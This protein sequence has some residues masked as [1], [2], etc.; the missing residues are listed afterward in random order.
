MKLTK[1]SIENHQFTII[2][3]IILLIFGANSFLTMPRMEDEPATTPGALVIVV[4]PGA[5][6]IDL[7]Q[8]V[9]DPIE[10]A[11]NEL[12]DIKKIETIIRD[13]IVAVNVD[14]EYSGVD[15]DDKYNEVVQQINSI[16]IDLPEDI[17]DINIVKKTTTDTKILQ[18]A[19]VSEK[20]E[21]SILEKEAEKLKKEIEKI[22]GIKKVE[23]LAVPKREVRISMDVEKMAQMNITLDHVINAVNS[24][25]ANIPGGMIEL[26]KKHFNIKTSGSYNNL[27][28]IRNTV[29]YSYQGKLIYLKNIAR[30]DF[31]YEDNYYHA[32]FNKRHCIYITA[33]QKENVNI[34]DLTEETAKII[35]K[36]KQN[37]TGDMDLFYVFDQ[38]ISVENSINDFIN[39]LIQGIIL[40]GFL[41]LLAVGFKA[42]IVVII[43]IPMSILIGIGFVDMSGFGLQQISI[44]ALVIALGLLVNNSI[45]VVENAERFMRLGYNRRDAAE[46]GTSQVAWPI[47]S[48]TVTTLLAFIPIIMMQ[49]ASGDYIR[50]LP[51]TVVFTLSASLFI[52][53]TLSPLL[54]SKL[55][56]RKAEAG[57]KSNRLHKQLQKFIDGPYRRMLQYSLCH[58]KLIVLSAG[59]ALIVALLIFKFFVGTSFFPKVEKPQF[60]V[61]IYMPEGLSLAAT[62]EAAKYVESVLD[63]TE[64]IKHYATNVG[65]GNP[66]IFYNHYSKDYARGVAEIY[67][68]L[69]EFDVTG[70]N[71]MINKLR[72]IFDK[73]V[74]ANIL[75]KE[76]Q[77]GI[78]FRYPVEIILTGEKIS[79][80]VKIA[81]DIE[82]IVKRTEGTLNVNNELEGVRSDIY[83]KINKE[84]AG[85]LG[86]AISEIDK[87]IRTCL[88]GYSVSK[89]RDSQGKEYDIVIRLPVEEKIT[90][91]DFD[92]I[93]VKSV[94]GKL[95]PL[96]QFVSVE[97]KQTPSLVTHYNMSRSAK[98]GADVKNDYNTIEVTKQIEEKLKNYAF[99]SGYSYYFSGQIEKQNESFGD[100]GTA[101]IIAIIAIFAVLV[102]QFRSLLQPLIIFS[103]VPLALVGSAFALLLS[104]NT[105]SFFAFIGAISLIGIVINDAIILIDFTNQMRWQQGKSIHEALMEAGQIRFIP[106][107]ITSLTTI[108]GLL[109]LTLQ[110]GSMWAPLGWTAIGG[111][112]LSTTLV[113]IVVPVLYE[114]FTGER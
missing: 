52:S 22:S 93:Y 28:E 66:K 86:V 74:G 9:A 41:I 84:K 75:V 96:N 76:F 61:Q 51:V 14:F 85:I 111:L 88:S 42:S 114:I 58:K 43:A 110:G 54:I 103:A 113:L 70:F 56:K 57:A 53:L 32:R 24:N 7:E 105:F 82:T 62:D 106:I 68:E 80:L 38:S 47:V 27:K 95:I 60:I 63:S 100:L 34:F 50:S 26:G 1:I 108:G 44:A 29:V 37:L 18:L 12:E 102:L 10:E 48:S 20:A 77:P 83:F 49:G 73:Y 107:L 35:N 78:P 31:D 45:V 3:F 91:D 101:A 112:T 99:P 16:R 94:S 5:S 87:T 69:E 19:L 97:F 81:K 104:G 21:F 72:N 59:V 8:L 89:F 6:P 17:H 40:V 109:P 46:K 30:V 79:E 23:I 55:F 25:N 11:V 39:N 67:V 33:E 15:A 92:R 36:F 2:V 98:I 65:H 90:M 4:Y 13:G 64:N 71:N